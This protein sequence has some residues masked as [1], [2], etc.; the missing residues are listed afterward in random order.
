MIYRFSH[1][2]PPVSC[3]NSPRVATGGGGEGEGGRKIE[4]KKTLLTTVLQ[5]NVCHL[6]KINKQHFQDRVLQNDRKLT[7][8]RDTYRK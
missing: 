6:R 1:D 3:G 8:T 4:Y 5:A 7:D 2:A